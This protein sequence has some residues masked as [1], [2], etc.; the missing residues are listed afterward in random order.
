ME[1]PS[2]VAETIR[3]ALEEDV[4]PGDCTTSL[5][6]PDKKKSSAQFL[7]KENLILAGLP[8]A[9]LV[10]QLLDRDRAVPP[11]FCRRPQH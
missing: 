11:F 3:R 6:V 8:F 1:I 7:A 10:F 4:G 5:L 9:S 2:G